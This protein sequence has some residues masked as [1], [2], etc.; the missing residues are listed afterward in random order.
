MGDIDQQAKIIWDYMLVHDELKPADI[1]ICL[2]NHDLNTARRA[3]ELYRAKIAPKILI[4][5]GRGKLTSKNDQAEADA[6]AAIMYAAGVPEVDVMIESKST[7]TGENVTFCK[8]YL[9]QNDIYLDIISAIVVTKPYMERRAKATFTQLWPEL[10]TMMTSQQVSYEDY[11]TH[12]SLGKEKSINVMVGDLQRIMEY[13]AKGWMAPQVVPE[14]VK[15]AFRYLLKRGYS[16]LL[17][18]QS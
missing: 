14:D 7:N 17:M 2:G 11:M 9:K 6:F 15:L 4:S 18:D 8:K 12:S 13:P 16:N 1:I 10:K 5:G 3:A